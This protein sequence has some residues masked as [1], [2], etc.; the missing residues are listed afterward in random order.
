MQTPLSLS[1]TLHA[2]LR[3]QGLCVHMLTSPAPRL[4]F[5]LLAHT[6]NSIMRFSALVSLGGALEA[7]G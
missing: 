4:V 7:R 5:E 2:A 3:L 1:M 6:G